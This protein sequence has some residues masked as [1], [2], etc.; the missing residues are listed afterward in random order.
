MLCT[1]LPVVLYSKLYL[2]V[3][4]AIGPSLCTCTELNCTLYV[5]DLLVCREG[6]EIFGLRV[7]IRP[8]GI[9]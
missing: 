2:I 1:R 9:L 6:L 5:I 7:I 8:V 4:L 3:L